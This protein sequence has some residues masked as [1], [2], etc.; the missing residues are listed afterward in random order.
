MQINDFT[1]RELSEVFQDVESGKDNM[2][3]ATQI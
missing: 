1:L 2:L 3:K